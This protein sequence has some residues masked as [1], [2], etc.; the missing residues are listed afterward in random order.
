MMKYLLLNVDTT[1]I[2]IDS[3][4][5]ST[6]YQLP[7]RDHKDPFDRLHIW[8]SIHMKLRSSHKVVN[9]VS[10]RKTGLFCLGRWT[11]KYCS[12]STTGFINIF[13]SKSRVNQNIKPVPPSFLATG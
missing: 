2:D 11:T 6:L 12:N 1:M 7:L 9:L 8:H 13:F 10:M 3:Q 4:T 5:I